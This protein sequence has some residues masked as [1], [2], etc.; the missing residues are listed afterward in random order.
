MGILLLG[1]LSVSPA[2]PFAP[3]SK[4]SLTCSLSP[5]VRQRLRREC[6]AHRH[7]RHP[8]AIPR[9]HLVRQPAVDLVVRRGLDR[10]HV[11]LPAHHG[12][13]GP[14]VVW[15]AVVR[16]R[17]RRAQ[18]VRINIEAHSSPPRDGARFPR[19]GQFFGSAQCC[20][21]RAQGACGRRPAVAGFLSARFQ[22]SRVRYLGMRN[23]N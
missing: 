5:S 10:H 20:R 23:E 9:H 14:A 17:G 4:P 8:D 18:D 19:P 7:D 15:Q 12:A 2:L 21:D 3:T 13:P 22:L 16:A 1:S 11:R 6:R